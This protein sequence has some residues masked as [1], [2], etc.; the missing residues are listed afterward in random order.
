MSKRYCATCV[1]LAQYISS[2][3][4]AI[5]TKYPVDSVQDA[6]VASNHC[7]SVDHYEPSDKRVL[8]IPVIMPKNELVDVENWK[9]GTEVTYRITRASYLYGCGRYAPRNQPID[10]R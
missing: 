2:F 1:L 8:E 5:G 10:R 4:R 3:E 7:Q 9:T 6:P